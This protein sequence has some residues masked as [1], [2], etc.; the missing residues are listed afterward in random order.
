MG[1]RLPTA[2]Y[3]VETLETLEAKAARMEE[4]GFT[5]F[6]RPSM[7]RDAARIV[8]IENK[9]VARESAVTSDVWGEFS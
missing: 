6:W 8:V 2:Y 3:N 4:D 7:S 5:F 1:V 9:G